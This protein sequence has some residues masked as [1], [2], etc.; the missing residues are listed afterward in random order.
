MSRKSRSE[1]EHQHCCRRQGARG[2][3]EKLLEIGTHVDGRDK[4]GNTAL[5]ASASEGHDDIVKLLLSKVEGPDP[6]AVQL[7]WPNLES[8]KTCLVQRSRNQ[9]A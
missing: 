1:L 5:H 6:G 2:A 8:A 3:V 4:N 7:A 9:E